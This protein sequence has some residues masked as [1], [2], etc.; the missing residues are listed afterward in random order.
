MSEKPVRILVAEDTRQEIALARNIME[1]KLMNVEVDFVT[2][3]PEAQHRIQSGKYQGVLSDVFF[4][5]ELC[6]IDIAK[7]ALSQRLSVVLITNTWHHGESKL[8]CRW[9]RDTSSVPLFDNEY[10]EDRESKN[11]LAG[12]LAILWMINLSPEITDNKIINGH[13][14]EETWCCFQK[15]TSEGEKSLLE[16][17]SCFLNKNIAAKSSFISMIKLHTRI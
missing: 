9:S 4:Y 15:L 8:V 17:S 2:T 13:F 7:C 10:S 5:G 16:C 3:A 12:F 14:F 11:W 1:Q 6:G